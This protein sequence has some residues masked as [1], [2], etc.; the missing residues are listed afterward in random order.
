MLEYERVHTPYLLYIFTQA[1]TH[2]DLGFLV[3]LPLPTIQEKF[4]NV[5]DALF[6]T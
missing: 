4:L 3:L 6:S 5:R 2:N 1:C